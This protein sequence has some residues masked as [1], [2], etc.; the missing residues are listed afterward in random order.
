MAWKLHRQRIKMKN[1]H[2]NVFLV[3]Q[4]KMTSKLW[5]DSLSK[6]VLH[7]FVF[8][9]DRLNIIQTQLQIPREPQ[10]VLHH[11]IVQMS[12][13]LTSLVVMVLLQR[14]YCKFFFHRVI[15]NSFNMI[16]VFFQLLLHDLMF[17]IICETMSLQ[18]LAGPYLRFLI[19]SWQ[20]LNFYLCTCVLKHYLFLWLKHA[21]S[22]IKAGRLREAR[23]SRLVW[24]T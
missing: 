22:E 13:S 1:Q 20:Y 11:I 14:S 4:S 21:L 17:P 8:P 7:T 12:K 5:C 15:I 3:F 24:A 10:N 18:V 23:R 16:K 2:N 19:S 6:W 9:L